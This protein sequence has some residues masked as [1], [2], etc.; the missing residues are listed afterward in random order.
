[1]STSPAFPP[2]LNLASPAPNRELI[3]SP[4]VSSKGVVPTGF[5]LPPTF[6]ATVSFRT[7]S[8]V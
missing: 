4:T 6:A 7:S 5:C 8:A 2:V 1:M 3:A